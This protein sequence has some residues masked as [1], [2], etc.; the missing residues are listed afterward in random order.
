[1]RMNDDYSEPDNDPILIHR[2]EEMLENNEELYYDVEELERIIDHYLDSEEL[3]MALSA[4]RHAEN[5]HPG[6]P[7]LTIRKIFVLIDLE[8]IEEAGILL[9]QLALIDEESLLLYLGKLR[10]A[11]HWG[12]LEE[13]DGYANALLDS[14]AYDPFDMLIDIAEQFSRALYY[15]KAEQYLMR[16]REI[17]PSN[18]DILQKLADLY[19]LSGKAEKSIEMYNNALNDTPF[20]EHLWYNLALSYTFANR[21]DD[22]L[23]AYDYCVAI[24]PHFT[25]AIVNK[26]LIYLQLN[27][28]E[29]AVAIF[30]ELLEHDNSPV[31]ANF[32]IGMAYYQLDD[33]RN[34]VIYFHRAAVLD[35]KFHEAHYYESVSHYHLQYWTLALMAIET[36]LTHHSDNYEYLFQKARVLVH[37][38]ELSEAS[39]IFTTLVADDPS[40]VDS[41]CLLS[42]VHKKIGSI[43]MAEMDLKIGMEHNPDDPDL[44]FH[45]AYIWYRIGNEKEA[46]ALFQKAWDFDPEAYNDLLEFYPEASTV[47][48]FQ[49]HIRNIRTLGE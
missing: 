27:R 3:D 7:S 16:A 47:E 32:Y 20:S 36:A 15:D 29:E 6:S 9:D 42:N 33:H 23:G 49:Q 44:S 25:S 14:D 40:D 21:L 46:A 11:L 10:M 34:A 1:M 26:G 45:L 8:S 31:Q 18:E 39:A 5:L 12:N 41:W 19:L 17:E 30:T 24:N 4:C 43:A 2:F 13:A 35:P 28:T 22:A 48:I 37:L 38:D